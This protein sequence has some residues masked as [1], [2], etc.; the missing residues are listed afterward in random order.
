MSASHPAARGWLPWHDS[1]ILAACGRGQDAGLVVGTIAM[2]RCRLT[3]RRA[4][5]HAAAP[6]VHAATALWP[7]L[8]RHVVPVAPHAPL[9]AA[10]A[11]RRPVHPAAGPGAQPVA[12]GR[13][14]PT[15]AAQDAPQVAVPG[16]ALRGNVTPDPG[17]RAAPVEPA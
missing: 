15:V 16:G 8:P 13:A 17:R 2:R 1:K 12:A 6:A 5:A 9:A 7:G 10:P 3:A 11:G 14:S 4:C